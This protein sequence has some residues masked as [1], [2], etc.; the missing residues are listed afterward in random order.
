MAENVDPVN[1]D[2][3][4]LDAREEKKTSK[5]LSLVDFISGNILTRESISR[6][7]P[8]MIFLVFLAVFYIS[9]S[10]HH[11]SLMRKS[12]KLREEVKDLRVESLNTAA[13]LMQISRQSEVIKL[14][15]QKELGLKESTVPPKKLN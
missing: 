7:F 1:F 13:R 2:E 15:E 5:K 4:E 3:D 10:Y 8:F 9:N 6:Q 11:D 12:Q 14:V